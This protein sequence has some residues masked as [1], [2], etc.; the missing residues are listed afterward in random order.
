MDDCAE[1]YVQLAEFPDRKVVKG[2]CYNISSHR[3]E[4][5]DELAQALVKEYDIPGGVKYLPGDYGVDDSPATNFGEVF[6][7]VVAMDGI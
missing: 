1:A 2:Q 5:L 7:W 6:S 4:T 3:F